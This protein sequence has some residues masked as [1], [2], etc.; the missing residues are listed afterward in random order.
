MGANAIADRF[1]SIYENLYNKV[2][3]GIKVDYMKEA[4]H[5]SIKQESQIW[6]NKVDE[7]LIKKVVDQLKPDKKDSIYDKS[8]DFYRNAPPELI[9]HLTHLLDYILVM[10]SYHKLY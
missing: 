6:F 5:S 1:A 7:A 2:E 4:V 10:G 8:S 3:L 9:V